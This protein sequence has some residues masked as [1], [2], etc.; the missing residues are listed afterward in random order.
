LARDLK[1]PPKE[2]Q[3]LS[4]LTENLV[5]ASLKEERA[6][7]CGAELLKLPFVELLSSVAATSVGFREKSRSCSTSVINE[8]RQAR[9]I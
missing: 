7:R 1:W 8:S 4:A 6:V 2:S 9:E 3:L 5:P